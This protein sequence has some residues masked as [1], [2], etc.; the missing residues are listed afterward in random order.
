MITVSKAVFSGEGMCPETEKFPLIFRRFALAAV[1]DQRR[2]PPNSLCPLRNFFLYTALE[3][4]AKVLKV[5]E[6]KLQA[7]A[8]K[9]GIN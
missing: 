9:F 2:A 6:F 1:K 7:M 8:N 5:N 3:K 4:A